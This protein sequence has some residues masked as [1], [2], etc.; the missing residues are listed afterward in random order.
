VPYCITFQY[1]GLP[2]LLNLRYESA[3]PTV[4]MIANRY[5]RLNGFGR[6]ATKGLKLL[7]KGRVGILIRRYEPSMLGT[8]QPNRAGANRRCG[9]KK[10]T[11][12]SVP[13]CIGPREHTVLINVPQRGKVLI[14]DTLQVLGDDYT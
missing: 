1:R 8:G 11:W 14:E 13:A 9:A 6:L 4:Y 7:V 10:D 3:F 2:S 5:S 12:C